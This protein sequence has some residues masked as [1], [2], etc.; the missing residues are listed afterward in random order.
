MQFRFGGNLTTT[1]RGWRS[2]IEPAL[3]VA[4][5]AVCSGLSVPGPAEATPGRDSQCGAAASHRWEVAGLEGRAQDST[6]DD[7]GND[8]G[9][10]AL[11]AVAA[12]LTAD[13]GYTA[14]SL[15]ADLDLLPYLGPD[16]HL[17]RGPP[18]PA[19]FGPTSA[20]V[21]TPGHGTP[22]LHRWAAAEREDSVQDP[23]DDDDDDDDSAS[24]AGASALRADSPVP[25]LDRHQTGTLI[26]A[27]SQLALPFAADGHSL[28]APP[29]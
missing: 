16:S 18:R 17:L 11:P 5:L 9:V 12:N 20:S 28:R 13:H 25:A 7:N 26:P 22:D 6:D 15:H 21:W 1:R 14:L 3:L 27:L 24:D 10:K 2:G 19:V 8:E 4:A 29:Q 23:F